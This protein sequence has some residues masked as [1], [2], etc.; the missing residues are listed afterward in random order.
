MRSLQNCL[1]LGMGYEYARFSNWFGRLL[2]W[3]FVL[4]RWSEI[5]MTDSE[6]K[7]APQAEPFLLF[8]YFNMQFCKTSSISSNA[9]TL[10]LCK[11]RSIFQISFQ[12][13]INFLPILPILF[14]LLVSFLLPASAGIVR[15]MQNFCVLSQLNL[16][17]FSAALSIAY[18]INLF[19]C[20][21]L[22]L[23]TPCD[24]TSDEF[25]CIICFSIWVCSVRMIYHLLSN[26]SKEF[27]LHTFCWFP[28]LLL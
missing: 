22:Q 7:A 5:W 24:Y 25:Y 2:I 12:S 4:V 23:S 8:P 16:R 9:N 15:F 20:H 14:G 17:T 13:W 19:F 27:L 11:Y 10:D 28:I 26:Q 18:S 1:W 6:Q 21:C 3:N